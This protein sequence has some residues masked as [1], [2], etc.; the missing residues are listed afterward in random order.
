MRLAPLVTACLLQACTYTAT[1][2]EG[3]PIGRASETDLIFATGLCPAD[4]ANVLLH[5]PGFTVSFSPEHK[6]PRWVAWELT[7]QEAQSSVTSR[8][9]SSFQ[10][11]INVKG[12]P[13]LADYRGSGY[14]KGHMCPAGDM[15]WSQEAMDA[16]FLLTNVCPQVHALNN[17]AWRSLEEKCREWAVRDSAI[18]IVCGPI[19]AD[20]GAATIGAG[21]VTVPGQ[22]FKAVLAPYANPPRGIAFIMPN[23][24]VEGGMQAAAVSIDQAEAAAGIDLFPFLPDEIESEVEK[25]CNFPLWSKKR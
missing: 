14:E 24:Y 20:S 17:G 21:G 11:D 9:G 4:S 19:L 10:P 8:K 3:A 1:G 13:Q 12:C 23:G 2:F 25:Q 18:I 22:F 5:Y 16:C 7:G 15:K 6:L